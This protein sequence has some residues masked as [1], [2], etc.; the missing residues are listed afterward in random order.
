[1]TC[2]QVQEL[3][4]PYIDGEFGLLNNLEMEHHLG[5]CE[6]CRSEYQGY[7]NVRALVHGAAKFFVA[8]DILKKRIEKQIRTDASARTV[9]AGSTSCI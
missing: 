8:P 9:R 2:E 7:L 4:H 6:V 5:E 3:I 1:M